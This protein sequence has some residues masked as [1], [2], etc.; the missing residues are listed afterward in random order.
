MKEKYPNK[1]VLYFDYYKIRV[2]L[3][4]EKILVSVYHKIIENTAP[5]NKDISMGGGWLSVK[6]N[7]VL[8]AKGWYFEYSYFIYSIYL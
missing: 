7:R 8:L 2:M 3:S 5:I 4:I 1:T 6:N